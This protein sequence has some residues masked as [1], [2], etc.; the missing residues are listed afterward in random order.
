MKTIFQKDDFLLCNVPVPEGYKQSQTHSGIAI[1]EKTFYLSS[2]P[3]P[4]GGE[5][6]YIA[7]LRSILNR[8]GLNIL[9]P[10]VPE[11][12]ENPCLYIQSKEE[13]NDFPTS[14][15]L[16]QKTPLM[17]PPEPYYGLPAFNSDPDIFIENDTIHIL[18]RQTYRTK[19][20]PGESLNKYRNRIYHIY[21]KIDNKRF[22]YLGTELLIDTEDMVCSPCLTKIGG[23]Y[24]LT[25]LE[26]NTYNEG[27]NFKGLFLATSDSISGFQRFD[28]WKRVEVKSGD[29]LPWHMSLFSYNEKL[30]TII[31]CVK[32]GVSHR[33]WQLLGEFS[34]DL[35][36][37]KIFQTPLTDY[38]SYRG[39]ATVDC[40]GEFVLYSTTVREKLVGGRSVDGR[41]IIMAH[42]P[43]G[44]VLN[45]VKQNG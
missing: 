27:D 36:C 2:S 3:Y 13:I 24:I 40:K 25:E 6:R 18:N 41:E 5:T 4:S 20:C 28:D 31:A 35:S 32:S 12:W 34:S 38:K 43:F 16:L 21:G 11:A 1:H 42:A 17:P 44:D 30:Y 23:K 7:Y 29:Y 26:T 10:F 22:Y 14:F 8:L 15:R 9:K 45:K 39:A 19:L 33:L 37:L